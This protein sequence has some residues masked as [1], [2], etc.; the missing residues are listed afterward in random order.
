M[1]SKSLKLIIQ[2]HHKQQND[3]ILDWS[4]TNIVCDIIVLP[5]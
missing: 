5:F 4:V 2:S 1:K 3:N